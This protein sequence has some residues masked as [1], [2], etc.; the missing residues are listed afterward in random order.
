MENNASPI[1]AA[2]M[3][4][5]TA[6]AISSIQLA[7]QNAR[8]HS[9]KIFR[10]SKFQKGIILHGNIL[11]GEK[12]I[13]EV[14]IGCEGENSFSINCHGNPIIV[15]NILELLQKHGAE[16]VQPEVIIAEPGRNQTAIEAEAKTSQVRATTLAGAKII[17]HQIRMGLLQTVQWWLKHLDVMSVADI[18]LGAQQ[19]LEDSR[20][21]SYFINGANIVIIGAPNSGKSTLFNYLCG[22]EKALVA[23]IAGTTRDWLSAKIRLAGI[24]AEIFDTAGLDNSL[25]STNIIDAQSQQKAR[26][27]A[28]K[29]DLILIVI[30]GTS[31]NSI[32]HY[33][34]AANS[35][36]LLCVNKSDLHVNESVSG[37]KISAKTGSGISELVEQIAKALGIADFDI[38][39]TVCFTERQTKILRQIALMQSKEKLRELITQLL[40]GPTFV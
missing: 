13:D 26:E 32:T 12:F 27:L 22:R 14:I 11:D 10:P 24:Q 6:A 21:A 17:Q 7:G 5:K 8:E 33:T 15:E 4:A 40:N 38:K 16:I 30:D 29:A 1:Y 39:K 2:L 20:I 34:D 3:T 19:I 37:I 28:Q 18:R 35:K 36:T 9:K 25:S 31:S 23:D